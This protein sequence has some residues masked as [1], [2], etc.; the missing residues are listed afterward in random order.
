M[1]AM[2]MVPAWMLFV[3]GAGVAGLVC[4]VAIFFY[5]LFIQ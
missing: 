5:V 3:L 1:T 4:L 2:V